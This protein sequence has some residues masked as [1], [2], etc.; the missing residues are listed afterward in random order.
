M[1]WHF[2]KVNIVHRIFETAY[3]VHTQ[4]HQIVIHL[5]KILEL[6]DIVTRS[7]P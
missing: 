5:L 1:R 2:L 7:K 6:N 3:L 4:N